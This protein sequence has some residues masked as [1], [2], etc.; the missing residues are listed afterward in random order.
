MV[1]F[2]F[3][4]FSRRSYSEQKQLGIRALLKER[5]GEMGILMRAQHKKGHWTPC[6]FVGFVLQLL[7]LFTQLF[8]EQVDILYGSVWHRGQISFTLDIWF[9]FANSYWTKH[10]MK[11]VYSK[12]GKDG[13]QSRAFLC[14]FFK[15]KLYT[16]RCRLFS[17]LP[18]QNISFSLSG[19]LG[20]SI[21]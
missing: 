9:S 7:K 15:K 13:G 18:I 16:Q 10:A 5:E 6:L 8:R 4:L 21:A 19:M 12:P 20:G 3:L 17:I 2:I 1:H 14:Q 11:I